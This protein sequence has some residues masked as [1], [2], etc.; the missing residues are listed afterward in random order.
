MGR[1][2]RHPHIISRSVSLM[3]ID[4]FNLYVELLPLCRV[5]ALIVIQ[6]PEHP[7]MTL[8]TGALQIISIFG[9]AD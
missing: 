7:P 1:V 3:L 2:E 5:V 8:L 4:Q 9:F 6:R